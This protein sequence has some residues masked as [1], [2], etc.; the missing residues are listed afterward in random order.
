MKLHS[1]E[2]VEPHIERLQ[3]AANK[4]QMRIRAFSGHNDGLMLLREMKFGKLGC[5]PLKT[6]CKWNLVEQISQTFTYLASFKAAEILFGWHPKLTELVLNLGTSSGTD[7]E[8]ECG[9]IAAEIFA[10][11]SPSSNGKLNKDIQKVSKTDAQY[12]YVF[13][14]CPNVEPGE[15]SIPRVTE[16]RIWSLGL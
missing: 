14:L 10:A 3:D 15:Y 9:G 16:V 12:K 8:S 5:D 13:F 11:T 7:I 1:A 2:D 4:T 6:D